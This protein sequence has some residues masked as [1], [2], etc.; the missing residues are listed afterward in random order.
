MAYAVVD[1]LSWFCYF[2]FCECDFAIVCLQ[3]SLLRMCFCKCGFAV[4]VLHL[5]LLHVLCLQSTIAKHKLQIRLTKH[6]YKTR[7]RN[8]YAEDD[9]LSLQKRL[10]R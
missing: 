6:G 3:M 4:V 9:L 8:T 1:L 2:G 10:Q 5:C 7:L